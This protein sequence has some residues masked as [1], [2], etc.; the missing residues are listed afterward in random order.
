[1]GGQRREA[2]VV[3]HP[4][5]GGVLFGGDELHLLE[6]QL[7]GLHRLLDDVAVAVTVLLDVSAGHAHK[8][9]GA[10]GVTEACWFQASVEGVAGN[11]LL[12]SS[13]DSHPWVWG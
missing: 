8:Q 9:G 4:R 7:E 5:S 10:A 3:A 13:Q 6:L 2:A 1:M 11:F 12:Q